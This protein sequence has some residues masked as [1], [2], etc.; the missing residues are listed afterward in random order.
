M[1]IARLLSPEE[2]GI[3]SV[4]MVLVS[5]IATIRD[6]GAG[7]YLVQ[8]KELTEAKIRSTWAM[9]LG[10]G[11]TLA[12]VVALLAA[13][14]SGFYKQPEIETI[15]WI[16]AVNFAINPFGSITVAWWTREMQFQWIALMR[17]SGAVTNAAVGIT[18]AWAGQGST[19]LAWASLATTLAGITISFILRPQSLPW[20]PSLSE[21]RHVFSFGSRLTSI[22]IIATL[23]NGAPEAF[24][25]R[26]QDMTQTGLLSRANGLVSMFDRLVMDAIGPITLPLFSR[27]VRSGE[28]LGDLYIKALA[29]ITALGWTFLAG[30]AIAA[31]PVMRILYGDQWD[32]AVT[33]TQILCLSI[34][35]ALPIGLS[36]SILIA[37][38]FIQ[39]VLWI[40]IAAAIIKITASYLGA[41]GELTELGWM[42]TLATLIA[43]TIW[44]RKTHSVLNYCW[45]DLWRAMLSSALVT[46]SA[47]LPLLAA[48]FTLGFDEGAAAWPKL[49]LAGVLMPLGFA[50]TAKLTHHPIY[51]ELM[52]VL[53][54]FKKGRT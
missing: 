29:L 47:C 46:S 38:G 26:L 45:L 54:H 31:F 36:Y 25:G 3:F 32:S 42:L 10:I 35:L 41:L 44:L 9:Q 34:A 12:C 19:S 49:L 6:M 24:L 39:T 37:K 2:I 20:L 18:L 23:S 52:K 30:L 8:E 4:T 16:L 27:K 48:R 5:V 53:G 22:S 33:L 50:L 43:V 11:V 51:D 28:P 7:Q 15:L 17:F 21:I 14:T 1:A 13:P 40:S